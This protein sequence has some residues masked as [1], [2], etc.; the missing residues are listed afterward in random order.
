MFKVSSNGIPDHNACRSINE[1]NYSYTIPRVPTKKTGD[2]S[3]FR[4]T[5]MGVIGL[6]INGV[7][8]FNPYDRS[9]CDAGWKNIFLS[10]NLMKVL[11]SL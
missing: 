8:I 10:L 5:N 2:Q 6:A 11:R 9:C 4:A 1:M 3:T 7:P